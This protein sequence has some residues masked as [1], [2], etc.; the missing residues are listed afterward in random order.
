M[1]T[2]LFALLLVAGM[3]APA[4]HVRAEEAQLRVPTVTRLVKLFSSLE[5]ELMAA[6][7]KGDST[8]IEK[9]LAD[10]FELRSGAKPGAPTARGEWLR[11]SQGKLATSIDQMAVHDYGTAAVVS[12]VWQ[13]AAQHRVFVVDV[14][15]RSGD[16]WKLSV[17]YASPAGD[18]RFAIPGA[19]PEGPHTEK[20]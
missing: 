8:A 15:S 2:R 3:S 19:A 17:R 9:L 7:Q 14:W 5:G 16:A 12:Y 10:D 13:P 6:V 4:F 11:H 18:R 20:K 1:T